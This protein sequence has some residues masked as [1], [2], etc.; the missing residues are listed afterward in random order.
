LL[1]VAAAWRW[2]ERLMP[3]GASVG[4]AVVLKLFL[5]P[6]AVWLALMRRVRAAVLGVAFAVGLA[7][8]GWATIGF[9]GLGGYPNLLH[10]LSDHE[11]SSSF[12]VVALGVRAHLPLLAAE[13]ISVLVVLALLAAAAWVARDERRALRDRDIATL[14]LC[15][16]AA[17]AGSPI[18]WVHFFLLLLVPLALTYPRLSLL[19][20]VPFGYYPLGEAAWASGDARKLALA[21]VT[22]L[23]ILG[24]A[25]LRVLNPHWRPAFLRHAADEPTVRVQSG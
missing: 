19:W 2:R 15:L 1:A 25:L 21:L 5:W 8:V 3:A 11:A 20:L 10:R 7:V 17:L 9:G 6:L 18:V 12:S 22:T 23:V 13:I 14:T 16:A 4:V 24:A